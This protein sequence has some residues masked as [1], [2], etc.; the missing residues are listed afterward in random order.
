MT[1]ELERFISVEEIN[2]YGELENSI[3]ILTRNVYTIRYEC[4]VLDYLT[5]YTMLIIFICTNEK[6]LVRHFLKAIC[7]L[8]LAFGGQKN[9]FK[10]GSILNGKY[11]CR[12]YFVCLSELLLSLKSW[13][14]LNWKAKNENDEVASLD[15]ILLL[16][17]LFLFILFYF[18]F[19]HLSF[20]LHLA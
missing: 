6:V 3:F 20:H 7:K 2:L 12:S 11:A 18:Y 13:S 5:F 9:P 19:L 14:A 4:N 10:V 16:L 8:L 17:L 1:V 15:N